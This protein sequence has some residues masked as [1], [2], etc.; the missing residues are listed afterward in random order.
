MNSTVALVKASLIIVIA[1]SMLRR[2]SCL[3]CYQ[4]KGPDNGRS[5]PQEI[6]ER[7]LTVITCPSLNHSL[8]GRYHQRIKSGATVIEVEARSCVADCK[9]DMKDSC[10]AIILAG[11][12]CTYSC[13]D[14]D[15]CNSGKSAA[16]EESRGF[17]FV[18]AMVA[19]I[20]CLFTLKEQ[21]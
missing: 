3:K 18:K 17:S 20:L 9:A 8:C 21:V 11:G 7:E 10:Q 5:Y 2:V 4:C 16:V 19:A 13:C 1:S 12:N 15:L 14:E 6:C